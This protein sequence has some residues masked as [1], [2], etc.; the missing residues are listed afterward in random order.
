[1]PRNGAY[2]RGAVLE[3]AALINYSL[4]DWIKRNVQFPCS[5]VD[6]IVP[7]PTL[8][9]SVDAA[10]LLGL[11]DAAALSTEPYKQWVIESFEG[12]RPRWEL[13]G[14]EFVSDTTLWETS[15]LRLLNGTHLAIAYLGIL[16]GVNTVSSFVSNPLFARYISRLMLQE[17]LPTVPKSDHD[18]TAY[19]RQLLTRWLN[20]EI[21]HQLVRIAR[22]GSDKMHPRL[23]EPLLSNIVAG[24]PSPCATLAVAAW[25]CWAGRL[26][27][28]EGDVEDRSRIRELVK[29]AGEKSSRVVSSLLKERSMFSA[30]FV[31]CPQF[32]ADLS[33]AV[34]SLRSRGA[35]GAISAMMGSSLS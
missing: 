18:L 4:V 27:Q 12:E 13:A 28:F 6:R 20:R 11:Q 25:I 34:D 31:L 19:S 33:A 3:R 15:K 14:A 9:D 16:A 26:M 35:H 5:V 1:M 23:L 32:E 30:D 22:N 2:L 24:R 29:Q 17:L 21:A 10:R 8:Q 7:S